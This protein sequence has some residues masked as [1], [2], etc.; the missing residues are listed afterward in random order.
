MNMTE[1]EKQEFNLM[2]SQIKELLEWKKQR[3][4]QQITYPI[5]TQSLQILNKYFLTQTG[6]FYY[7]NSS[8]FP[9]KN[10]FLT[11]NKRTNAVGVYLELVRYTA[12]TSAD[13][14]TL[15]QDITNN[16]QGLFSNGEQVVVISASDIPFSTNEPPSPLTDSSVYYVVNASS[17]GKVIQLS[18]TF[19]GAA[20]NLTTTGIG[21][22]YI[23][24][25]G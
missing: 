10:I 19:G 2:K 25:V 7:Y 9:F 1:Q 14:L 8:G 22:Q 21:Q 17:G 3:I 5:D 6:E 15:G 20:I 13:T 24:R 18:S 16:S 4:A 11:Q 23:Y 12:S